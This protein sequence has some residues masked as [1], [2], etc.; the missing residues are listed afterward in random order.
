MI[1]EK[2]YHISVKLHPERDADLIRWLEEHERGYRS[3]GI[4]DMLRLGL[5]FSKQEQLLSDL[6]GLR[7]MIASELRKVLDGV[8]FL[9]RE[10]KP[11]QETKASVVE[12]QYGNKLDRLLGSL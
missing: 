12:S 9:Q 8:Q 3:Q 2:C 11:E 7:Q 10:I 6:D 5:D 4:R 1:N